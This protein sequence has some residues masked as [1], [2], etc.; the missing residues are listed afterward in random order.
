VLAL[1]VVEAPDAAAISGAVTA[2]STVSGV[3]A[4]TEN[5]DTACIV[6]QLELPEAPIDVVGP[7]RFGR[8]QRYLLGPWQVPV[9]W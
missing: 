6:G 9:R 4:A 5:R 1:G 3:V 8:K 2:A 7:M